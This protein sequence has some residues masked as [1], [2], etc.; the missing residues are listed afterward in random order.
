MVKKNHGPITELLFYTKV[1][2]NFHCQVF[3]MKGD[4]YYLHC[5]MKKWLPFQTVITVC[6]RVCLAEKILVLILILEMFPNF[7]P[8][9][10][11]NLKSP[12]CTCLIN[13][14]LLQYLMSWK[15]EVPAAVTRKIAI[16]N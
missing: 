4:K 5:V 14:L 3:D 8:D 7:Q 1:Y 12:S 15:F 6:V 2:E 13:I 11:S 9:L 16:F 10:V